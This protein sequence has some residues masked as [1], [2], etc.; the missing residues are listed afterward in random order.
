MHIR[1]QECRLSGAGSLV[2]NPVTVPLPRG[3]SVD[4]GQ[5]HWAGGG[6]WVYNAW[7]LGMDS[8]FFLFCFFEFFGHTR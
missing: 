3:P 7:T 5:P 6:L 1:V 4:L 8:A 2:S